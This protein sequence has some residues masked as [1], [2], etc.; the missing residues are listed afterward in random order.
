[1]KFLEREEEPSLFDSR[2]ITIYVIIYVDAI[3]FDIKPYE[4]LKKKYTS[5]KINAS[6]DVKNIPYM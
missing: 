5:L 3:N 6:C 1:L 2:R 4:Q